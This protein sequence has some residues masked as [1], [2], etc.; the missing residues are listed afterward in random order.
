MQILSVT[1]YNVLVTFNAAALTDP[2]QQLFTFGGDASGEGAPLSVF[3]GLGLV[4]FQL[5]TENGDGSAAAFLSSPIQWFDQSAPGG[6]LTPIVQPAAIL[7]QWFD[8]NHFTVV[9][10]NSAQVS[11]THPYNVVVS[12][13]G[14]IYGSEPSIINEPPMQPAARRRHRVDFGRRQVVGS[15][16]TVSQ[17]ESAARCRTRSPPQAA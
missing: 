9:D 12:Y 8:A 4:V 6:P 16:R 2:E 15:D 3:S 10:F 1:M 11:N 14:Q 17:P 13:G 5:Q 7:V